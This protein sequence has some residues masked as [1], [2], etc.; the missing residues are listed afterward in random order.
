MCAGDAG[1]ETHAG[2]ISACQPQTAA[3]A[4]TF[5]RAVARNTGE[6]VSADGVRF[7]YLSITVIIYPIARLDW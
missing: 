7:I 6:A 5:S 3:I 4:T 2:T 1:A